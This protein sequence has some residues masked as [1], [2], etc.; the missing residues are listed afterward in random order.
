MA[1]RYSAKIGEAFTLD[2]SFTRGGVPI[3]VESILKVEIQDF[4]FRVVTTVTTTIKVETGR[5]RVTIPALHEAGELYDV[6]YYTPVASGSLSQLTND[7]V[8][9]DVEGVQGEDYPVP[10]APAAGVENL[11]LVTARFFDS[12]GNPFQGVYIRFTPQLHTDRA[13][14]LG[15]IA[16]DVT[17]VSDANGYCS[18]YLFRGLKG[19]LTITGIG[20]VREI[21]VPDTN[22]IA[23]DELVSY[24]QDPFEVQDNDFIELPRS[25]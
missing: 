4:Y 11:C 17:A 10:E 14:P 16:R 13:L 20:L 3:D 18:F 6:W 2:A 22:T 23:L 25:S 7:V 5:Y 12:A 21:E 8:V 15:F 24:T 19:K 9:A 1:D